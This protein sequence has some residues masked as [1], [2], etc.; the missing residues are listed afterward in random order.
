MRRAGQP[1]LKSC[2]SSLTAPMNG[3]GAV[4]AMGMMVSVGMV[5]SDVNP[6]LDVPNGTLNHVTVG[7]FL[8]AKPHLN[9]PSLSRST[10]L[11]SLMS[12][13]DEE[14]PADYNYGGY[15]QVNVADTFK[16][17]RYTV[18]R[19]LG[20]VPLSFFVLG[21]PHFPLVGA[22]S[23]PYGSSRTLCT[24]FHPLSLSVSNLFDFSRQG[25]T[26]FGVE[27]H[28]VGW[29]VLRDG[30]GRNSSVTPNNKR[31]PFPPREGSYRLLSRFVHPHDI[32]HGP[33]MHHL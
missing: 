30:S 26:S 1:Y 22:T 23:P 12:P 27:N 25:E 5:C 20:S 3:A 4:G 28:Q 2:H 24:S 18:V 8:S 15:L 32:L 6:S 17:G 16:D 13:K 7:G 10:H 33:H 29:K 21:P 31:L 19:K 14:S 11:V 9:R